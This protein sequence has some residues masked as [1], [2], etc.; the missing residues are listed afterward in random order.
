MAEAPKKY[1]NKKTGSRGKVKFG[2]AY[3]LASFNNTIVT[4]TDEEG[5][6]LMSGSPA[7]LG[8]K[9]SKKSTAYV[10]TKAAEDVALRSQKLGLEAVDVF[11]RGPGSGRNAAVKGLVAGGLRINSLSDRTRIP[12]GGTKP[13]KAPRK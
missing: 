7:R 4:L 12:H 10:A 3:V 5:N 1:S 6:V 8:F 2:R 11:I 13:R 9:N